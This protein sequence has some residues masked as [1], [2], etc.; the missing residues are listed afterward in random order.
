MSITGEWDF[1]YSWGCTGEY[2]PEILRLDDDGTWGDYSDPAGDFNRGTWTLLGGKIIMRHWN[3]AA[4]LFGDV[5][6]ENMMQGIYT[7]AN[8][9]GT[10]CWYA[11]RRPGAKRSQEYDLA[12]RKR[13]SSA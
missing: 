13:G 4:V 5:V 10:G 12:G 7:L 9:E 3:F 11:Q 6:N 1:N 8:V 2:S